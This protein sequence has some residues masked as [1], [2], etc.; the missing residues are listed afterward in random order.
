METNED[1]RRRKLEALIKSHGVEEVA[2]QAGLSA[3][4][5]D[6]IIKRVLLPKKADGTRSPR[7]LADDA[8]RRIER[9]LGL[10][11]GWM[12]WPFDSFDAVTYYSLSEKEQGELEAL[13]RSSAAEILA[14]R[15]KQQRAA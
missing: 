13:M 11:V 10:A 7:A 5:L 3:A 4:Y 8:A 9:G 2:A 12:D 15:S 6:Q 1:R 14:R